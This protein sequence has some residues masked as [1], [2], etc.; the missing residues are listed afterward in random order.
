MPPEIGLTSGRG[1]CRFHRGSCRRFGLIGA[2]SRLIGGGI[3]LTN[4][5]GRMVQK[6][7]DESSK[8]AAP[9]REPVRCTYE[10]S[11]KGKGGLPSSIVQCI[12][13]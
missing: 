1:W 10:S 9:Q 11:E 7:S 5:I 3:P 6:T 4:V 13:D 2:V 8:A 12:S